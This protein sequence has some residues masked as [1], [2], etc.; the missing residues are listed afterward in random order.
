MSELRFRDG[1][2]TVTLDGGL[3]AF[4]RKALDAAAGE[5]VRLM[6]AAAEEVASKARATWYGTS[7]L[8]V[9]RRTGKS[10]DIRVFTTVSDTEVRV[11]VGS[12]D[13]EK[14]IYVHTSGP[15]SQV[16]VEITKAE[17][18]KRKSAARRDNVV[19]GGGVFKAR[20]TNMSY[21]IIKD[22]YY[23]IEMNKR[24]GDRKYL[25]PNLIRK[26]MKAKIKA[27]TPALGK[28]IADRVRGS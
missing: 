15:L 4:V 23:A 20:R 10:G 6:E 8:S 9:Q 16:A 18:D 28:A 3:E 2:V 25:V 24:A 11:S 14:A 7:N 5:T 26:P 21:G 13:L 12:T 19:G 1:D 27:I 17:Y 22:H